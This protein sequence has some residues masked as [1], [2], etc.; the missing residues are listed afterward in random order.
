MFRGEATS[1]L[2]QGE[3]EV[4]N[5][6]L[7]ELVADHPTEIT[8]MLQKLCSENVLVS[9]NR[10]R[11]SRYRL[12]GGVHSV[13]SLF[14]NI[15][16]SHRDGNSIHSEGN[17]IRLNGNS[18][19]LEGNS[20]RLGGDSIRL[21]EVTASLRLL[22]ESVAQ[23]GKASP[24]EIRSTIVRLC[25]GHYISVEQLADLLKRNPVRI[26]SLFLGPMVRD[27]Q[28]RLRFPDVPNHPDQAYTTTEALNE[29]T[30]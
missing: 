11:W 4:S 13:P 17:S 2:T 22:A 1:I 16:S 7:Q 12:S 24:S 3:G 21:V 25:T 8:R 5:T 26:R 28:L 6:R 10:R 27:G 30:V 15:D 18:S 20:I 23:K 19:H 9:D 14:N 29:D